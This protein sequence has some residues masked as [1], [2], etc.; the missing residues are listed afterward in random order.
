MLCCVCNEKEAT[1]HLT[2]I[3]SD[4][5]RKVDLCQECAERKGVNDPTGLSLADLLA[6]IRT[7]PTLPPRAET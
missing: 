3:A 1:V 4:T 7:S 2:Q 6:G 5:M